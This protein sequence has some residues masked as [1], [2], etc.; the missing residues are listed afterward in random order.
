MTELIDRMQRSMMCQNYAT[1]LSWLKNSTLSNTPLWNGE[2]S[3]GTVPYTYQFLGALSLLDELGC[4]PG[5]GVAKMMKHDL[6]GNM[7]C[8][9]DSNASKVSAGGHGGPGPYAGRTTCYGKKDL[10]DVPTPPFW[11]ALLYRQLI[12]EADVLSTTVVS[13]G[14]AA[15]TVHV[16]TFARAQG[17]TVLVI[18]NLDETLQASVSLPD[19]IKRSCTSL[20]RYHLTAIGA[21]PPGEDPVLGAPGVALNGVELELT[22]TSE[23]P[24]LRGANG[25]CG[26][27]KIGPMSAMIAI[28]HA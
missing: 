20:D 26:P 11:S 12:G 9:S 6:F 18:V 23:L 15:T 1:Q 22:A 17:G 28:A 3:L 5:Q 21:A 10:M 14:T 16:Y 27:L 7:F 4:L 24:V 25:T 8:S 13:D 2:G 19:T